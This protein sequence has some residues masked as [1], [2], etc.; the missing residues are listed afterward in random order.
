MADNVVKRVSTVFTIKDDEFNKSLNNINKH[1]KLTQSEIKLAG[2]SLKAY[3]NS[4]TDLRYKQDALTKQIQ[5]IKDKIDL[6]NKS[7]EETPKKL[8]ENKKKSEELKKVK[9]DLNKKYQEAVKVYGEESEEVQKLKTELD[10]A[11]RAYSEQEARVRTNINTMNSHQTSLKNTEAELAKVQGELRK[12][13]EELARSNSRWLKFSEGAEKASSK[14]KAA[15]QGL[16]NAGNKVLTLTAPLVGAGVAATKLGMDFEKGMSRVKAISGA[17]GD[18]F[19]K[20]K[21]QALELGASTSFSAKEASAGMENLASAGFNTNEIIAAMPGLLDLAASSGADLATASDIAA[22][23]LRGF[24]LDAAQAGHVADVLAK[25][26]ADTNAG[27]TDTGEALKYV[28][29]VAR[30]VGISIEEATAAIG[31]LAN[32][33]I[34]G[35]QAGT[36]LRGSLSRLAKPTKQAAKVMDELKFSAFDSIGK[37]KPLKDQIELLQ[38]SMKKMTDEQKQHALVTIYGQEAL[39]GMLALIQAGPQELD[40]LT[41]GFNKA[42]GAAS[43][44]AETMLDNTAGNVEEMMGS[45][46][47]AGIKLFNAIGPH[48][49]KAAKAVGELA[50]IFAALPPETQ[51]SIVKMVGFGV[52]A[53]GALKVVGGLA[54]GIGSVVGVAGK[55]AGAFGAAQ[56]ATAGAGAAAGVAGG[57]AGFGALASGIGAAA[58]A[59][60]PWVI[61]A[62]AVAGAGY[63]IYKGLTEETVPAVDLFADKVET[64]SK[65]VMSATGAMATEYKT[66][67]IKINDSTKKAVGAYVNLDNGARDKLNSLYINSTVITDKI[68][69][70]TVAKFGEMANQVIKGYEKQKTESLAQLKDMFAQSS[71]LTTQEEAKILAN[72]N[73]YYENKKIQTQAYEKQINEIISTASKEKRALTQE[74]TTEITNLQN[75]MRVNA[76]SAL[77]QNEI[78]AQVILQRMKDYDGRI[79]AEQASQHIKKLNESRD[80]AVQTANDEYE[81][82]IATITKMRDEAKTISADQ[83]DKMIAEAKRQ[84]DGIVEKAEE[85]RLNA[86]EKIRS[87]NADLDESVDTTTGN[88]LTW[89]DKLKRWWNG[90]KPEKKE[91]SYGVEPRTINPRNAD[92][93]ALGTNYFQGGLTYMN[94]RGYELRQLPR[95]SKIFNHEASESY[96]EKAT[97]KLVNKLLGAA[98]TEKEIIIKNYTILDGKIVANTVD[99]VNGETY[100]TSGRGRGLK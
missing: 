92:R 7:L 45:L 81:K 70:D 53:G 19:E 15:G 14:L 77:S 24:G 2:E 99:K 56:V 50:D 39:S 82:R 88:I 74:E 58:L 78:E 71:A 68:K 90:W 73:T 5:N 8:E 93:N 18:E 84:R 47:T 89:W 1:M 65:T 4:T 62:A 91:F 60:A 64:T 63:L 36:T 80:K 37:M 100:V 33:G 69:K 46:E 55:V 95:G 17:A 51:E 11:K 26:A 34:K 31:L 54:S 13:N 16:N 3:G 61:G 38:K 32:A 30:A 10:G 79:T 28:A 59:A 20:L 48:I 66:N 23:A 83:A 76:V 6:Y 21:N 85:T 98:N 43:K 44:M 97:E 87:M 72:T 9:D 27:I 67:V 57:A 25:A 94:E 75:K 42:D 96:I 29:P 35:S 22:S 86:I 12:T 40:K 41:K 49:N 52:A